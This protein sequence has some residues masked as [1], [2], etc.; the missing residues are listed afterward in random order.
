MAAASSSHVRGSALL[1]AHGIERFFHLIAA[2]TGAAR[3][4]LLQDMSHPTRF[5]KWA[6]RDCQGCSSWTEFQGQGYA[7]YEVA[8]SLVGCGKASEPPTPFAK[9]SYTYMHMPFNQLAPFLEKLHP[10]DRFVA[11]VL[12]EENAPVHM[13]FDIDADL[14]KFAHLKGDEERC[15]RIFISALKGFFTH[16]FGRQMDLSGL[17]LLQASNSHKLSWHVHIHTEAFR[18]MKQHR[19]FVQ[20]FRKYLELRNQVILCQRV[21]NTYRHVVDLAPYSRNQ[22]FRAPYNQKP[23]KMPLQLR[24]HHWDASGALQ[25]PPLSASEPKPQSIS[26]D[27]LFRAHPSLSQP[28]APGY[29]HLVVRDD[30]PV[31]R[32]QSSKK[33]KAVTLDDHSHLRITLTSA[34]VS[35]VKD[36]LAPQLGPALEMDELHRCVDSDGNHSIRGTATRGTAWCPRL[37][38][39]LSSSSVHS[40]NRMRFRLCAGAIWLDCYDV[41]CPA[42]HVAWPAS[43][44]TLSLLRGSET[45][46]DANS[47]AAA[48]AK[49]PKETNLERHPKPQASDLTG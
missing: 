15:I 1:Q 22:N 28:S 9:A 6:P 18:D 45:Q 39:T 34:E 25:I 42:E 33:R 4:H 23:G 16:L 14:D 8:L 49:Q 26:A 17:L 11:Y 40:S 37:R 41:G 36:A 32:T 29:T 21:D 20:E 46:P 19:I 43:A 7:T 35:A 47:Q 12:T 10:Q 3:Q 38:R 31:S 48:S 24:C 13:Y 2:K 44:S 27:V 30:T 5:A